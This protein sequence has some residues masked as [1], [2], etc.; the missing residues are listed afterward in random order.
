MRKVFM[1][2]F[3]LLSLTGFML[4]LSEAQYA[5]GKLIRF[6]EVWILWSVPLI[7]QLIYIL[8]FSKR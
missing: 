7:I 5:S 3:S 4:G 8:I 1:F 2:V 6:F